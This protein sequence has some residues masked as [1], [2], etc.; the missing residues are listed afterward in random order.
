MA[1]IKSANAPSLVPFSMADIER[2]AKSVLLRAQQQAEQL[3]AA[4]QME[5]EWLKQQATSEGLIAG[6]KQGTA[7][8]LA[9]GKEAGQQQALNEHRAQLQQ[10]MAAL[11]TAASAIEQ[12]RNE[13]EAIGLAEV[14]RLAIAIARRVTKRQGLIQPEVLTDNLAEAMK[15]VVKSADVRVAINPAQRKTLDAALPRLAMQWPALEHVKVIEDAGIAPGGCRILTENGLV[16]ADLDT[17]LNRIAEEL[18]PEAAATGD[19]AGAV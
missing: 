5:A 3:L 1:V 6:R 12:G 18:L 7:E 4:A 17:Q 9:Q 19:Q 15:R 16:D 14:A 2:H 13:L 10:A 11:T 8:G